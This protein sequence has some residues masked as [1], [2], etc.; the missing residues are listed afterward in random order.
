MS[1]EKPFIL[2]SKGQR[3][4]SPGTKDITVVGFCTLVGAGF[5]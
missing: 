5:F 3:S 4:R 2:G 1:P